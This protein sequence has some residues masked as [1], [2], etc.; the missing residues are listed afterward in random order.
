MRIAHLE[1]LLAGLVALLV[2][3]IVEPRAREVRVRERVECALHRV[4]S[5]WWKRERRGEEG[6]VREGERGRGKEGIPLLWRLGMYRILLSL[7]H[8]LSLE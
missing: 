1:R 5:K 2:D 7:F 6:G 4:W 8:S 3:D